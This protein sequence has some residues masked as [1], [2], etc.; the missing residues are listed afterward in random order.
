VQT[1]P[2]QLVQSLSHSQ[3]ALQVLAR[4]AART[5]PAFSGPR[6]VEAVARYCRWLRLMEIS[7][8]NYGSDIAKSPYDGFGDHDSFADCRNSQRVT[9]RSREQ[10]VRRG[11]GRAP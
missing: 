10:A 7:A 8:V 11:T 2:A 1:P 6:A 3:M 4:Q 9:G 5:I